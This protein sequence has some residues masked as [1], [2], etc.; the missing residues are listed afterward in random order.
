MAGIMERSFDSLT[1][2]NG[3]CVFDR[4]KQW[5][6][7]LGIITGI[8]RN[9]WEWASS[10]LSLMPFSFEFSI[11]FL[12]VRRI[13]KYDLSDLRGSLSTV[14]PTPETLLDELRKQTTVINMGMRQEYRIQCVGRDRKGLPIP[15]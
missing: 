15:T 9:L 2:V 14:N 8:E 6:R 11:L 13:Q 3:L 7:S 12:K 1:D 5:E 10:S 4:Y